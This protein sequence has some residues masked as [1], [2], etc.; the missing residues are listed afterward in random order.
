MN[1]DQNQLIR[2]HYYYTVMFSPTIAANIKSWSAIEWQDYFE[3]AREVLDKLQDPLGIDLRDL[4]LH[5]VTS[6]LSKYPLS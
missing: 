6:G 1:L 3:K 5:K 4:E 2:V